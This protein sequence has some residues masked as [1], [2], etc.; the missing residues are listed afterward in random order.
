MVILNVVFSERETWEINF[1]FK[2]NVIPL[3]IHVGYIY[4]VFT[5]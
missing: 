1:R 4:Y 2:Y 5:L 3:C